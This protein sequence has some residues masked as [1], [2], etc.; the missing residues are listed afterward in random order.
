M[1]LIP[2]FDNNEVIVQVIKHEYTHQ[3]LGKVV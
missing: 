2:S 1:W 3:S